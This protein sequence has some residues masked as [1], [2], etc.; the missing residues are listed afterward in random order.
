[1]IKL[2]FRSVVFPNK[3]WDNQQGFGKKEKWDFNL[4]LSIKINMY[5]LHLA[6]I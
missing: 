1:M 3:C 4:T 6:C 2:D 5:L